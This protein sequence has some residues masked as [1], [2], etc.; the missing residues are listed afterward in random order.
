MK[1][2]TLSAYILKILYFWFLLG[3]SVSVAE[4]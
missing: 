4:E 3:D 1:T 2:A